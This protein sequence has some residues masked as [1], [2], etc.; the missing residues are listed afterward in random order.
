MLSTY[1]FAWV[2]ALLTDVDR[3]RVNDPAPVLVKIYERVLG[4]RGPWP[5]GT[6]LGG[7]SEIRLRVGLT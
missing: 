1:C 3:V 6:T 7:W 2:V 4:I 5:T